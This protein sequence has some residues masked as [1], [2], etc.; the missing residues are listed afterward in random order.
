M[1]HPPGS[2]HRLSPWPSLRVRIG[3]CRRYFRCHHISPEI[4]AFAAQADSGFVRVVSGW[5]LGYGSEVAG[6]AEPEPCRILV[7]DYD[8]D[9]RASSAVFA[10]VRQLGVS[11]RR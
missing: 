1:H 9:A 11:R 2:P 5:L 4:L 8:G 6:N 7:N 10:V 3:Q